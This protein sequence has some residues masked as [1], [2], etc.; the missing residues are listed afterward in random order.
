MIRQVPHPRLLLPVV[1]RIPKHLITAKRRPRRH[2]QAYPVQL[3]LP[4]QPVK[5]TL[6]IFRG[7]GVLRFKILMENADFLFGII[8]LLEIQ[9]QVYQ[10]PAV[11]S[12]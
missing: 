12:A 9:R 7:Y 5:R 4:F 3:R 6:D 11:L 2:G 1:P 10:K 8:F